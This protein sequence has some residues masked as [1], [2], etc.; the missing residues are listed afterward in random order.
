MVSLKLRKINFHARKKEAAKLLTNKSKIDNPI[1]VVHKNK[2][3]LFLS[4]FNGR[5]DFDKN[6]FQFFNI[7][8]I[9]DTFIRPGGGSEKLIAWK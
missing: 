3:K 8:L 5:R 6:G 9:N 2:R 1:D 7:C 4:Y